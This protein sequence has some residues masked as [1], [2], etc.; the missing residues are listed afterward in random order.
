MTR[1]YP[2]PPIN[3]FNQKTYCKMNCS[4]QAEAK[5]AVIPAQFAPGKSGKW[6]ACLFTFFLICSFSA[7]AQQTVTGKVTSGDSALSGVSVTV[8]NTTTGTSTDA[9]GDYS[10][11]VPPA[12]TL[13]FSYIGFADQ[14]VTVGNQTAI[15]VNMS[16]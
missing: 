11:K 3:F 14:E 7:Y 9:N 15:N 1:F 2:D 13:V 12:A 6:F 5:T 8:K 4:P 16:A 10:I